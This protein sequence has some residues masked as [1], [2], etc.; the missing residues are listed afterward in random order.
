MVGNLAFPCYVVA[1]ARA[2]LVDAAI[3]SAA[4]LLEEH[5]GPG[6]LEVAYVLLTH[7]HYDHVG[8]LSLLRRL[9]PGLE[10][11]GSQTAAETLEKPRV[12]EFI[13]RMNR[14]E[15][16]MYGLSQ[17]IGER[18]VPLE[19]DDLRVDRVLADGER[20]E[21]GQGVS[22]QGLEA[23]GHTR[24]SMVFWIEPDRVLAGGE[25]L[26]AYVSPTEVQAQSV[27][28]FRDYVGTLRR[29]EALPLE[30]VALP[31]HGVRTGADARAHI[32][33]ALQTAEAFRA[34][35]LA[36]AA[37][38]DPPERLAELLTAEL[39]HGLSA[40]QPEKAF[41]LN[42]AAMIRALLAEG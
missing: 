8:A 25:A 29:L 1:G 34:R 15:E 21:L 6:R 10:L 41:Q 22:V 19:P 3:T 5:F 32:P 39:R 16:A 24:C 12:R 40:M 18:R 23:P 2:A 14:Q 20:L 26:G 33:T 37:E 38:G 28:S 7:T 4:P 27:S 31:H 30:A 42:L 9:C 11:V 13:L 36:L 17:V 35:V